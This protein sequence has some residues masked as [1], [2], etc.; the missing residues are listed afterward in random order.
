MNL[1]T[2]LLIIA[3]ALV[4][5]YLLWQPRSTDDDSLQPETVEQILPDFTAENLVSRLYETDGALAHRI[6]ASRMSHF[7]QQGL[8]ELIEPV[9]LSYLRDLPENAGN[10]W[11]ISAQTGSFFEGETLE[12]ID[13]VNVTNLSE[14]GYIDNI[15]TEYLKID[16]VKQ[17]MVTDQ[18]VLIEGPQFTIR[19]IGIRVDLESQQ[20]ELIEHVETIYYPRGIQRS[21]RS[22]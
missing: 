3:I 5:T 20:L 9:Y 1:R 13:H 18:P 4:A 2:I 17:E 10:L 21:A 11:Q 14:I 7:S 15:T 16:L 6:R 8:T 12:L 19:G 22:E